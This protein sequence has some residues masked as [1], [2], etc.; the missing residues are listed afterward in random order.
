MG[1]GWQSNK[2]D[3]PKGRITVVADIN[4]LALGEVFCRD[5]DGPS[6]ATSRHAVANLLTIKSAEAGLALKLFSLFL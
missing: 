3:C 1:C 2:W 6:D 5:P 4:A